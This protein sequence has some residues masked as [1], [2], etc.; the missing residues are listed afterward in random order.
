MLSLAL[1]LMV[2]V[3]PKIIAASWHSFTINL[4]SYMIYYY[5]M[6][7]LSMYQLRYM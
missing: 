4:F 3:S 6:F 7:S 5:T 2:V 1:I